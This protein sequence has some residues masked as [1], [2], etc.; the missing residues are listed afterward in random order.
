MS[1]IGKGAR[2]RPA[3]VSTALGP[4][5][6]SKAQG[7]HVLRRTKLTQTKLPVALDRPRWAVLH[8]EGSDATPVIVIQPKKV[9]I[10]PVP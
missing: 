5:E 7:G 1:G 9:T 8:D 4:P 10:A 3:L 6:R 2:R